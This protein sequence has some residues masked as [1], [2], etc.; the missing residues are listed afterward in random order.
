[1][2]KKTLYTVCSSLFSTF[3]LFSKLNGTVPIL[4]HPTEVLSRP[5]NPH[6]AQAKHRMKISRRVESE[7]T[8]G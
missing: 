8:D 5:A 4:D 2:K 7:I 6:P 3:P 1:M